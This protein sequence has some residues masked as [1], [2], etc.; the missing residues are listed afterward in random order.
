M[1]EEILK[2]AKS[3]FKEGLFTGISGNLS[4]YDADA[5]IMTIT[6]TSVPYDEMELNDIVTMTLG[7]EQLGGNHKPSSEW[8][9]HAAIYAACE[10][11]AAIIHT[12]SSYATSFA[13]NQMPIPL[14]LIEMLPMLGGDVQ[15]A[16]F[17]QPGTTELGGSALPALVGRHACLLANHG[18]LAVG[19]TLTQAR[20][21]TSC[22]EEAA[23]VYSLALAR[24]EV[25]TI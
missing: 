15:V 16:P 24:G 11:I 19:K 12:H 22:L 3:L 21:R 7:G 1:R 6:P 10:G 23:K 25:H 9:M 5:G 17:A 13:V 8:R 4:A 18:T 2:T 14:I 20:Q